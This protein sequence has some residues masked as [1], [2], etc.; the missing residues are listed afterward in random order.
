MTTLGL[1]VGLVP[2]AEAQGYRPHIAS[3]F[4]AIVAYDDNIQFTAFDRQGGVFSRFVPALQ[5]TS[6]LKRSLA[7]SAGYS[8][9]AEVFREYPELNEFFARQ[10]GILGLRCAPNPGT[11]FS[12]SA[13]YVGTRA[14]S[15]LVQPTGLEF[16]RGRAQ[17]NVL[18]AALERRITQRGSLNLRY[19]DQAVSLGTGGSA[20]FSRSQSVGGGWSQHIT[21]G[22]TLS[23]AYDVQ[24]YDLGE[25]GR[26][27]SEVASVGWSQQLTR[28][29]SVSVMGGPRMY[30]H[31]TSAEVSAS[32]SHRLRRG[33]IS[34]GYVRGQQAVPGEIVETE[35]FGGSASYQIGRRIQLSLSPGYFRNAHGEFLTEVY[36]VSGGLSARIKP[37]LAMQ[38][39]YQFVLQETRNYS[40]RIGDAIPRTMVA[41]GLTIT[42]SGRRGGQGPAR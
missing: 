1:G 25:G 13:G 10:Q 29:T 36:R 26:S 20:G 15:E 33:Q 31:S 6:Q 37:W 27:R 35:S 7:L 3:S 23:L 17:G 30:Q 11:S 4:S 16:P 2:V 24:L 14:A 39:S 42:R 21:R 18:G 8:T 5:A 41:A 34:L 40:G 19:N 22:S 9:H 28:S 32:V 38:S 12:L